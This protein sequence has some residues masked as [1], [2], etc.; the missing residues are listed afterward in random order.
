MLLMQKNK[1]P[2]FIAILVITSALAGCTKNHERT[3]YTIADSLKSYTVFQMGSY[4][5]YRLETAGSIDNTSVY[6]DPEYHT[7]NFHPQEQGV[8]NDVIEIQFQ[9][10]NISKFFIEHIGLTL[11]DQY[12]GMGIAIMTGIS[13]GHQ[14]M[15]TSS[16]IYEYLEYL[17]T[18]TCNGKVFSKVIH[19]QYTNHTAIPNSLKFEYYFVKGVGL[20]IFKKHMNGTDSTW[21]LVSY[22]VNQ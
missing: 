13:P 14:Y 21:N 6:R 2:T 3:H 19:S 5:N 1:V 18:L 17:D 7:E 16:E 15:T 12:G 4:W 20:V 11:Y 8:L 22:Y 10:K 9:S